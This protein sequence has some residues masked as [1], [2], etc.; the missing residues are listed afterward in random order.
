MMLRGMARTARYV[1]SWKTS[2]DVQIRELTV[3]RGSEAVPATLVLPTEAPEKL[4]G[5]I[6]I[7]GVSRRGRFH[8]QLARFADA[9]ASSGAAVLV[10][11]IPEWR[12]PQVGPQPV[13][14]KA[15]AWL[16]L[17]T[18]VAMQRKQVR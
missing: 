7:G 16:I 11:E 5:W 17:Q 12:S 15:S 10:P 14:I 4:P 8:P 2:A 1:R 18:D 3:E 9:L 6:A 13:H